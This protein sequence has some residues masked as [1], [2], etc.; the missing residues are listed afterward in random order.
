MNGLA[1]IVAI[2]LVNL[3]YTLT[4]LAQLSPGKLVEAH[5]HLEGLSNCT[6]CHTLGAK[7]TNKKC[8]DCHT[9]L[10]NRIDQKLGYHA[11]EK[12]FGKP[13]IQ[14]HS[15]HHGRDFEIIRF[16]KDTFNHDLTGYTLKGAHANTDC[17]ECHKDEHIENP[18]IREKE[19][20]YLGL[21]SECLTCHTDYHQ[22][23]LASACSDCHGFEAFEP[24]VNF[25]HDETDFTLKGKHREV[26]CDDC[27]EVTT[28]SGKEFHEFAGVDH[29][30]CADCH[31]DVHDNKFGQNCQRCHTE[32]SFFKVKGI[33]QFDH[34]K[35]GFEL[36][37]KHS[38]LDCRSCHQNNY[39]AP[40]E[41]SRCSDCHEDYHQGQFAE[42][43]TSH[44]CAE[45][46]DVN[47]FEK[48]SFSIQE[49]NKTDFPLEGAHLATPCIACHK[50]GKKW[51]FANMGETCI[52]CHENIHDP[53]LDQSYYEDEGCESCHSVDM[54]STI[55]FNHSI[56][57]F[58]LQGAHREQSCRDCHFEERNG[59]S[60]QRFSELNS[61]CTNCHQD[62]HYG[63][64]EKSG[65]TD[66]T[67]CHAFENWEASR[68]DHDNTLFPLDGK[69]EDV[70]C[71][72]CHEE[73]T[74]EGNTFTEYKIEEFK[75]ED[76]HQ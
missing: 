10:K 69:H 1:K 8:L 49:H 30:S 26:E 61:E 56:T 29:N 9:L 68:F 19:Y 52:D 67:R 59:N 5:A 39:T 28:R 36:E 73:K 58:E 64:F 38:F 76:C 53:Y 2:I 45:C 63:Q 13:C 66:C 55:D 54:W 31:T 14:C 20:S 15:D 42:N 40:I 16:K 62:I 33:D 47:G 57:E 72:K 50:T 23:T 46:H 25:N 74:I 32:E 24:A 48:T 27:H 4:G 17:G 43:G 71:Y 6:K 37:G 12:V 70:A 34:S 51:D 22:N 75:C 60:M 3:M 44:D 41:H 11:S 21:N 65:T 35:T 7:I 18:K